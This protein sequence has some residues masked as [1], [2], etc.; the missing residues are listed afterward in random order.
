MTWVVF[1]N[2]GFGDVHVEIITLELNH[3][4]VVTAAPVSLYAAVYAE[5]PCYKQ[6]RRQGPA[7]PQELQLYTTAPLS[8]A[9]GS[10]P[11]TTAALPGSASQLGR[12][13]VDFG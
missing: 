9:C 4:N 10:K 13:P 3:L 8:R 1:K 7:L 11:H 2:T 5:P 6:Q 12:Q